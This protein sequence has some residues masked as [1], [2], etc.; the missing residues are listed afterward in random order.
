LK[1]KPVVKKEML[2]VKRS[3]LLLRTSTQLLLL[4]NRRLSSRLI[5]KRPKDKRRRIDR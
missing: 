4:M 1:L 2:H 3:I 5:R